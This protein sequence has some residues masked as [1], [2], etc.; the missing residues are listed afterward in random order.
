[1]TSDTSPTATPRRARWH[2]R[3]FAAAMASNRASRQPY[4]DKRKRKFFNTLHG[5]VLEIGPGAGPNL[6]YLPKTVRWTGIEPNPAMHPYL[7]QEAQ[8]VGIPIRLRY[9]TA[10]SIADPDNTYDAVICTLVLCSV[11]DPARTLAEIRR[12]LKPGG[13]FIFIE[14]VAAPPDTFRRHLQNWL[15]PLWKP[16]SDGCHP[17]RETWTYLQQAGFTTLHLDRFEVPFPI[18][19]PHIGG[20]AVK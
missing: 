11:S 4:Y 12:V 5:D 18:I 14:H 9:D 8:R 10:D 17:N 7:E 1:M 20:Y 13:R 19:T 3:M 2:Q 6:S 15:K 16:L